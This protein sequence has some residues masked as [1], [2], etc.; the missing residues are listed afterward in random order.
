MVDTIVKADRED[1]SDATVKCWHISYDVEDSGNKNSFVVVI[2]A[3]DM[4]DATDA[5]E[6]KTLANAKATTIKADWVTALTTAS[7]L[8]NDATLEGTVTL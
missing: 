1:N 4:T 5:A 8:T 6:A 7:T 2:L 3:E